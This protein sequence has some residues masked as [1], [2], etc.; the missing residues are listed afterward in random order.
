MQVVH[1]SLKDLKELIDIYHIA[2]KHMSDEGN[3]TQWRDLNEFIEDVKEYIH[4]NNFYVLKEENEILGFFAYIKNKDVAYDD[5][6]G[7]WLNDEPYVVIHKIASKYHNRGVASNMLKYVIEET[8]KIGIY[9]IKIDTHEKNISMQSFLNKH[10]FV[11][12]GIISYKCNF[13]DINTL[14]FAYQKELK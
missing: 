14:R 6:R 5:I 8:K 12:C 2:V 13:N 4:Q 9:N 10:D 7:N 3:L 1:A 11:N